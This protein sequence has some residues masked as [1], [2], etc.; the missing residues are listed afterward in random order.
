MADLLPPKEEFVVWTHLSTLQRQLYKDFLE[1]SCQD[2]IFG[3]GSRAL[4]CITWLKKLCGM[5]MLIG[6]TVQ[7]DLKSVLCRERVESLAMQSTK[8]QV[9]LDMVPALTAKGHRTL[10]FSQSTKM[11]DIIEVT[12]RFAI[13]DKIARIDGQ[14]K[15]RDRQGLV[16]TFN[17][18]CSQFD[19]MLLSTR[20]GTS[21]LYFIL[22]LCYPS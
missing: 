3:E 1:K 13:G 17:A 2:V 8:L 9:L 10:I 22:R 7:D 6:Q 21:I 20:A 4:E 14:T 15:E 11:L 12:L 5:P 16:D 19:V 18:G